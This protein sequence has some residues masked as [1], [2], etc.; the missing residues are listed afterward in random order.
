LLRPDDSIEHDPNAT[1][2]AD[3]A[4]RLNP[5]AV[6]PHD[7]VI[8][9]KLVSEDDKTL[10]RRERVW[11][12]FGIVAV[13]LFSIL[14]FSMVMRGVTVWAIGTEPFSLSQ[15]LDDDAL[16]EA[17]KSRL[18][19]LLMVVVPQMGLVL[20]SLIAAM[21]SPVA[22][23]KRLSLV[24]GRWPFWAWIAAAFVTP[25]VGLISTI[26]M[27]LFMQESESLK[28]MSD[29]FRSHGQGGFLVP[30]ALMIGA[31]PALC[32]EILFR[33][34]VQTRLIRSLRPS[35]GIAF[36]S[37]LFAAFH[38]DYVHALGVLPLGL[39]LGWITWQ[40]GSLF[41]AMMGHFVNNSLSVVLMTVAGDINADT[42][43][44]PIAAVIAVLSVFSFGILSALGVAIVRVQYGPPS[45]DRLESV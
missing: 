10:F 13:S 42:T 29:I 34:Y 11:T 43:N 44:V 33:G 32:E 12:S 2:D 24:R 23:R 37:V 5:Y 1:S 21:L 36:A 6:S 9:A 22:F 19:L 16:K 45:N 30:L 4:A 28:E 39:Y 7:E 15:F 3:D 40:S 27:G 14:V 25:L 20:P 26:L 35:I 38:M 31:T 17:F 18:G 8:L 41:P